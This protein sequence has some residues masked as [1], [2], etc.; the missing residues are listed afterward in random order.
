MENT[1]VPL[2]ENQVGSSSYYCRTG[3]GGRERYFPASCLVGNS[4]SSVLHGGRIQG[5]E[6]TAPERDE[7][8][9]R[10]HFWLLEFLAKEGAGGAG[11]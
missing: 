10:F 8:T 5:K 9:V 6:E 4:L 7:I 3:S 11:L 1:G 2:L